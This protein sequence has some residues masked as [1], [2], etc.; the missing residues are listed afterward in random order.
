MRIFFLSLVATVLVGLLTSLVVLECNHAYPSNTKEVVVLDKVKM[1]SP[2]LVRKDA[3]NP[4][5]EFYLDGHRMLEIGNT[6][7]PPIIHHPDCATRDL[8]DSME[9]RKIKH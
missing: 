9:A 3:S 5:Y 7:R 1:T 4:V 6:F 2:V 8:L